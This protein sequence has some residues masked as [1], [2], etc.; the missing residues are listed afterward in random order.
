MHDVG[1]TLD[2]VFHIDEH[3]VPVRVIDTPSRE[4]G[5][6]VA[7]VERFHSSLESSGCGEA[8]VIVAQCLPVGTFH[9]LGDDKTHVPAH[10]PI[11]PLGKCQVVVIGKILAS[12]VVP[13]PVVLKFPCAGVGGI[14]QSQVIGQA[15]PVHVREFQFLG[16]FICFHLSH[17]EESSV[18]HRFV[19][20]DC[21]CSCSA[22]S[23]I[24]L[25]GSGVGVHIGGVVA[26]HSPHGRTQ[27]IDVPGGPGTA[28]Y[29]K[30]GVA[31]RHRPLVDSAVSLVGIGEQFRFTHSVV[32][33]GSL[34]SVVGIGEVRLQDIDV[35]RIVGNAG[36]GVCYARPDLSVDNGVDRIFSPIDINRCQCG[37]NAQY[38]QIQCSKDTFSHFTSGL[39]IP[40]VKLIKI[41]ETRMSLS[42]KIQRP[43]IYLLNGVW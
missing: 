34:H 29:P 13:N 26:H 7:F 24:P 39:C 33:Q 12:F 35:E 4:D 36:H 43:I 15:S 31:S 27:S 14:P 19:V 23:T 32:G 16:K 37:G 2:H 17:P 38:P 22:G 20:G 10:S 40:H 11:F 25:V 28:H 5:D 21:R 9:H 1:I 6:F 3:I 8:S 41:I 42:N 30:V 18:V